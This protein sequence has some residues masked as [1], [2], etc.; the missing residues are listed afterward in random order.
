MRGAPDLQYTI[1][2]PRGSTHSSGDV[3]SAN[4]SSQGHDGLF[5]APSHVVQTAPPKAHGKAGRSNGHARANHATL[6]RPEVASELSLE[7][8]S[9]D[10]MGSR[11]RKAAHRS[12]DVSQHTSSRGPESERRTVLSSVHHDDLAHRIRVA[13]VR[14]L[15]CC[16]SADVFVVWLIHSLV[17]VSLILFL[18]QTGVLPF[19]WDLLPLFPEPRIPGS[20]VVE[21]GFF[22]TFAPLGIVAG[23]VLGCRRLCHLSCSFC[24]CHL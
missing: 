4:R 1:D 24:R 18:V 21:G 3:S 14:R 9:S 17:A 23:R 12:T 16:T 10:R 2:V 22:Y 5:G 7:G 11:N 6:L 19:E 15:G 8:E 20:A 13:H